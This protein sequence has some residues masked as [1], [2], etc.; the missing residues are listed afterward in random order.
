MDAANLENFDADVYQ[1][2]HN[3]TNTNS[4]D[5]NEQI[6]GLNSAFRKV[7]SEKVSK[8]QAIKRVFD[9]SED[10]QS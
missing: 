3:L 4:N 7:A 6:E 2:Y 10:T 8:K 5:I 1:Q 9:I